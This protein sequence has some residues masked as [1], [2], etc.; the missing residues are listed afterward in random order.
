M[1]KKNI[2]CYSANLEANMC[3][4]RDVVYRQWC[5]TPIRRKHY[6]NTEKG[7]NV[8]FTLTEEYGIALDALRTIW[9]WFQKL[10]VIRYR[11]IEQVVQ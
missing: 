4:V 11:T 3:R 5:L 7:I 2:V 9:Y 6:K 8:P 1:L 10:K